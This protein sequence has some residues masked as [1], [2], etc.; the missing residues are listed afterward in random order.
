[1]NEASVKDTKPGGFRRALPLLVIVTISAV[2]YLT[3]LHRYL[4]L[5]ALVDSREW[6]RDFVHAHYALSLLI[7]AGAYALFVALSVPGAL[8]LTVMG[9][10][11]FGVIVG[12]LLTVFAATLGATLLFLAA[13]TG[14]GEGL[15]DRAGPWLEKFRDGFQKDATSYMLFLRLVPVFPFWLVNLAPA[16]LGVKLKTFVWTTALGILP[17]TFAYAF[18]GAGLD[19]VV[20]AQKEA[21]DACIAAGRTSCDMHVSPGQLVTRELVYAFAAL[22]VVALIP[23]V[24]KRIRGSREGNSS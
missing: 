17:G 12:G 20:L 9:G 1:M 14:L 7:F 11:L 21:I 18:A 13:S 23:V 10:F 22:G 4:S 24:I 8:L 5:D 16:L 2:V 3:G 6:L 15:R 19:S